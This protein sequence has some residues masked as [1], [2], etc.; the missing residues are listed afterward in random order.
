MKF[1]KGQKVKIIGGENLG[2]WANYFKRQGLVGKIATIDNDFSSS[3][4]KDEDLSYHL[5]DNKWRVNF[6]PEWLEPV[7]DDHEEHLKIHEETQQWNPK[8]EGGEKNMAFTVG[9]KVLVYGKNGAC[10]TEEEEI[11]VEKCVEKGCPCNNLKVCVFNESRSSVCHCDY[12]W[13]FVSSANK[14]MAVK[15]TKAQKEAW[16][17]DQQALY[18]VGINDAN[19]ELASQATAVAAL[20]KVNHK[21]LVAQAEADI[22]EAEAE[23]A[24]E[25]AKSK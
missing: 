2:I 23:E 21:A 8:T 6:Q 4:K 15:L 11:T 12:G 13:K 17:K 1:K 7:E 25:K 22:A 9:D 14:T 24:K 5:D 16:S 19:G 18:A 3:S 20:V 10:F